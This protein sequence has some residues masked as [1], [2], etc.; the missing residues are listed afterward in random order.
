MNK[1][2]NTSVGIDSPIESTS[3]YT[4]LESSLVDILTPAETT[5]FISTMKKVSFDKTKISISSA[6]FLCR[7]NKTSLSL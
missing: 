6:H 2:R 5:E 7:D 1:S 4:L 3:F